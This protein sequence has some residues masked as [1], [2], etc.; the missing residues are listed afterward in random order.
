[1]APKQSHRKGGHPAPC[2][3]KAHTH[4]HTHTHS[5]THTRTRIH[6]N[7]LVELLNSPDQVR[8]AGRVLEVDIVCKQAQRVSPYGMT[9]PWS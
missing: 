4:M 9:L 6:M 7:Y 5:F 3:A 2:K 8:V 1:M